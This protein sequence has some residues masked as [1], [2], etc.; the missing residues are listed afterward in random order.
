M[1]PLRGKYHGLKAS[2]GVGSVDHGHSVWP[3][4]PVWGGNTGMV[5]SLNTGAREPT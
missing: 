3:R 1:D 4:E 5:H 2:T